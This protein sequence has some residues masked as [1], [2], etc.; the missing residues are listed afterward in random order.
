MG[1][2]VWSKISSLRQAREPLAWWKHYLGTEFASFGPFLV[3]CDGLAGKTYPCP[4]SGVRL[5]IRECSG[6]YVAFPTGSNSDDVEDRELTWKDVHAWRLDTAAIR[7]GIAG[8]LG[9]VGVPED[10]GDG[11]VECA[12]FCERNGRRRRVYLCHCVGSDSCAR[13]AADGAG[14]PDAGCI[15]FAERHCGAE[16]VLRARGVALLS[17]SECL[18]FD[19]GTL[20]GVCSELCRGIA[21]DITNVELRDHL[22]G[23][24]D[25]VTTDFAALQKENDLLKQQLA[26]VLA[27]MA[28]QVAPEF[29]QWIFLILAAGSASAAARKLGLAISTFDE[30]LKGYVERGGL[31][32]TL[33]SLVAV[34]RKGTGRRQI[35][36]FNELFEEHQGEESWSEPNVLRDLLDG[37]E[38]LN[39]SNWKSVREELM[40]VIRGELPEE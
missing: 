27:K 7:R 32:R 22:A 25:N 4:D 19:G 29:F 16:M 6:G 31:Y 9:L 20:K 18:R 15:L 11:D 17:M 24:F 33:F 14:S 28:R 38:G 2:T 35:E 5:Q 39:A 13:A 10:T 30:R 37:L 26:A 8:A 21:A 36:R 1:L 3:A 23:R 34:R 12:G 40:E